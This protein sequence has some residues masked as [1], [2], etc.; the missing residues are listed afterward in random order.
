[1]AKLTLLDIVQDIL[2]D[3]T[4]DEVNSISD[5]IESLQVAQIVKSSFFEMI[6]NKNW[7]HLRQIKSLDSLGDLTRP[8]HM[9]LPELTKEL[10]WIQYNS[11]HINTPARN[12]YKEITYLSPDAFLRKTSTYDNTTDTV[13]VVEDF[14]G[15]K[16]HIKNDRHPEYWTSFDDEYI[17]FNSYH[18]QLDDTLQETHSRA[19]MFIE[20][21]WTMD[22]TFIPDL[23]AEAFPALLA[24]AK[25][26]AFAR[27]KQ[28]PDAK[29]EQQSKR[30]RNWLSR[31]AWRA[32]GGIKLPTY[33]RRSKK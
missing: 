22:D 4:D 27:L 5:T 8:T 32:S 1:M 12:D 7:P 28:S 18:D 6:G 16:F 26:V 14:S 2:S 19:S 9:K 3:M 17:I 25:S 11:R 20:P 31:K 13:D 24:E 23:P 10:E 33:A 29:A 30:Q 15:I 21:G